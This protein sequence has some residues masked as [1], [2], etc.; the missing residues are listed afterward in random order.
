MKKPCLTCT[1]VK[2]PIECDNKTCRTWQDWYIRSWNKLRS[3]YLANERSES[4]DRS[5]G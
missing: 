1:R 5:K 3:M 4:N 2:N